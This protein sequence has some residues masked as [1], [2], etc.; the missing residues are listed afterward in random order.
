MRLSN[1]APQRTAIPMSRSDTREMRPPVWYTR[2]IFPLAGPAWMF[3][4]LRAS[5][6]TGQI[7]PRPR[8]WCTTA[9]FVPFFVCAMHIVALSACNRGGP[10]EKM[11][12]FQ[13]VHTTNASTQIHSSI[14]QYDVYKVKSK[15]NDHKLTVGCLN[16]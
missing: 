11:S 7:D 14:S 3:T 8:L 6:A 16:D 13:N 1:V 12:F 5:T 9:P 10:V 2:L 15:K 4:T